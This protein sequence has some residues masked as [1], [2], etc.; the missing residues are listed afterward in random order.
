LISAELNASD[1]GDIPLN[2]TSGPGTADFID[3]IAILLLPSM[4]SETTYG[5]TNPPT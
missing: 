3:G 1:I 5:K 4:A 2:G